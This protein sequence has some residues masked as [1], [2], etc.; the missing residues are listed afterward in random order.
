MKNLGTAASWHDLTVDASDCLR[1][2]SGFVHR[3]STESS[4]ERDFLLRV[5]LAGRFEV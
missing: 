1:E 3:L 5:E 4:A 2:S